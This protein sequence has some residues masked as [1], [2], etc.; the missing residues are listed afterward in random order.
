M[1][2]TP[3]RSN[4]LNLH[5]A[6][7]DIAWKDLGDDFTAVT[8]KKAVY[9]DVPLDEYFKLGILSNPEAKSVPGLQLMIACCSLSGKISR[10]SGMRGKTS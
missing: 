1:F 5:V 7:E 8:G 4:G 9:K 6:T 2:D 3:A 10:G